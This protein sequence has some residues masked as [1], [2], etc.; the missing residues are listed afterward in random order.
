MFAAKCTG[1]FW[2][3]GQRQRSGE[4]QANFSENIPNVIKMMVKEEKKHSN[5]GNSSILGDMSPHHYT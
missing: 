5:Y 2:N 4:Y 1:Q 3:K